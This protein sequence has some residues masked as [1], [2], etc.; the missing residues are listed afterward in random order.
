M[1]SNLVPGPFESMLQ[2]FVKIGNGLQMW[3]VI[4]IVLN[5]S[6]FVL[7]IT[8]AFNLFLYQLIFRRYIHH[9]R[10]EMLKQVDRCLNHIPKYLHFI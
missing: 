9:V 4:A 2:F 5:H 8:F 6:H 7:I 10:C 1:L 3:T